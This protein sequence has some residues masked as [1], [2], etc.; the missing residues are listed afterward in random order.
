MYVVRGRGSLSP[1]A[2]HPEQ[3]LTT[4]ISLERGTRGHNVTPKP[5]H[6][7]RTFGWGHTGRVARAADATLESRD[8]ASASGPAKLDRTFSKSMLDDGADK[9]ILYSFEKQRS[10]PNANGKEVALDTL[11]DKAEEK[12]ESEKTDRMVKEY[13]VLDRKGEKVRMSAKKGKER[14]SHSQ[15]QEESKGSGIEDEDFEVI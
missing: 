9:D 12:W 15:S 1:K 3:Y 6:S 11:V 4:S 5:G 2:W 7:R 14:E 13:E 8:R 10:S